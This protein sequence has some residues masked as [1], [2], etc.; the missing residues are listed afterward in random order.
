MVIGNKKIFLLC[1]FRERI[2]RDSDS[3]E[4]LFSCR[5]AIIKK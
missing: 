1:L 4:N 5:C 3:C 2:L